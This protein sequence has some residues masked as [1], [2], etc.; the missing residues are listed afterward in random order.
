MSFPENRTNI[1]HQKT[2]VGGIQKV[3]PTPCLRSACV[4]ANATAYVECTGRPERAVKR[5]TGLTGRGFE[6]GAFLPW[7][8]VS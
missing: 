6:K 4:D 5:M 2:S 8:G 1:F 3:P 7:E